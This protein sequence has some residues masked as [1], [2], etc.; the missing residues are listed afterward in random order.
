MSRFR[1]NI[2]F[3]LV[4]LLVVISIIALL[5]ALLLP[6]LAAARDNARFVICRSNQRQVYT[7]AGSFRADENALLPAWWYNHRP[8]GPTPGEYVDVGNPWFGWNYEHWGHM[9]IDKNYL[10]S[11]FRLN[12]TGLPNIYTSLEKHSR[13]SILRCPEGYAPQNSTEANRPANL[14]PATRRRLLWLWQDTT[15][16]A[17][18]TNVT[19]PPV[20]YLSNYHINMN[21]GSFVWY[22][23]ASVN[24][25]FYPRREWTRK[26]NESKIFYIGEN[27][28]FGM[29]ENHTDTAWKH[30]GVWGT[31]GLTYNPAAPHSSLTRANI[32]YADGHGSVMKDNYNDPP[33]APEKFPFVWY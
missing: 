25:G 14:D 31:S 20:Y 1:R 32:I 9:L 7:L 12:T 26:S 13:S 21:A 24:Q 33:V 30:G 22:H 3:T 17:A 6:A 11:G 16:N 28:N 4:E 27:V 8:T 18:G 10:S 2:A 23:N 15:P 29:N 5:V 19:Y